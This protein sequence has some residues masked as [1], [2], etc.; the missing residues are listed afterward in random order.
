MF[1]PKEHERPP[2]SVLNVRVVHV[3]SQRLLNNYCAI[4]SHA[5]QLNE[6][7]VYEAGEV[8][9]SGKIANTSPTATVY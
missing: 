7:I 3:P 4:R 9:R 5:T 8:M 1:W 6:M 2:L